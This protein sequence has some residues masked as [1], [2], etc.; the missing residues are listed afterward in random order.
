[1]RT[2]KQL[3]SAEF[4]MLIGEI[5]QYY[6]NYIFYNIGIIILIF[7]VFENYYST[8]ANNTILALLINTIFW[9]IAS[10]S[11]NYLCYL[12]QDEAMMGT[13]EQTFT[14]RTSYT[15]IMIS[16]II[17]N[18]IF[19]IIKGIVICGICIFLFDKGNL[20]SALSYIAIL[21]IIAIS[22]LLGFSFYCIGAIFGGLT[23][24][25]KRIGSVVNV[26]SYFLLL[27]T[28]VLNNSDTYSK[29]Y[30]IISRILPITNSNILIKNICLGIANE[31]DCFY[32]IMSCCLWIIGSYLIFKKLIKVAKKD[33][34]LGQ[35]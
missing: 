22:L 29:A 13:L 3:I 2:I 6:L 9:Q 5:K 34:K 10:S 25:Y 21:K 8:S 28:G 16:K 12:V 24:Y 17:V 31:Y 4:T 27:F 14:T 11:L 23:L 19:S 1:M 26:I 7:G 33:G 18:L 32:F 20:F 30:Q 35:Y 15:T